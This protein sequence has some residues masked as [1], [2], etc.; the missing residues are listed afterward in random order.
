MIPGILDDML[1]VHLFGYISFRIA[2]AGL[3]AFLLGL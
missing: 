3:T 1:G 2:M